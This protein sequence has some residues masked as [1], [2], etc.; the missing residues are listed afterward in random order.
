MLSLVWS[1]GDNM[2]LSGVM[3]RTYASLAWSNGDTICYHL[4]GVIETTYDIICL[5]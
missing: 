2:L 4:P 3:E 5:E 1:N